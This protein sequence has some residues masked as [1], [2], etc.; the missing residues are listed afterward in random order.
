MEI[1]ETLLNLDDLDVNSSYSELL[2]T[3]IDALEGKTVELL[4]G[5]EA[6]SELSVALQAIAFAESI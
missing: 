6:A 3:F 1:W 2:S 4:T 5:R